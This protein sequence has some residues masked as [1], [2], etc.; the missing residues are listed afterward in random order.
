MKLYKD[1]TIEGTPEEIA[2]YNKIIISSYKPVITAPNQTFVKVVDMVHEEGKPN[3]NIK[4]RDVVRLIGSNL[5]GIVKY[6]DTT[7][8]VAFIDFEDSELINRKFEFE[9]LEVLH[10][11]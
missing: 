6:I 5:A 1:G 2:E 4:Q 7:E 10:R 9:T 11:N 3:W 8:G